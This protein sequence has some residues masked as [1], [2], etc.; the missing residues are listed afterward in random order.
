MNLERLKPEAAA[1]RIETDPS[2]V[3]FPL[4][5]LREHFGL[6][7]YEVLS[8]LRSGRLRA[9]G[10]PTADGG[11]RDLCVTAADCLAWVAH[12][13]TPLDLCDRVMAALRGGRKP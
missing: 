12:P 1:S 8:E 5:V 7:E 2:S 10:V 4:R 3:M 11:W 13:F 6:T 9:M